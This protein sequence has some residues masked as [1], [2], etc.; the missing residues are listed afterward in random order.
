MENKSQNLSPERVER[1]AEDGIGITIS[2]GHS[3]G[4]KPNKWAPLRFAREWEGRFARARRDIFN[5]GGQVLH[6]G[7]RCFVD[8][9]GGRGFTIYSVDAS[10]KSDGSAYIRNV[11]VEDLELLQEKSN[12]TE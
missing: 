4:R 7:K 10:G 6:K 1:F 2:R 9:V 12:P 11:K 5:N 8:L 3:R